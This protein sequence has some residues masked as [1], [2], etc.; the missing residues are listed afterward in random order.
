M[1][2]DSFGAALLWCVLLP[3][4]TAEE[5][6]PSAVEFDTKLSFA[7]REVTPEDFASAN[8]D[9]KIVEAP[10]RI[11]ANL[12][13]DEKDLDSIVYKLH[14]PPSVE[15]VD[16]LPKTELASDIAGPIETQQKTSARTGMVVSFEGGGKVGYRMPAVVDAAASAS[17]K[18]TDERANEVN[19]GVQMRLLP[20]KQLIVAAGTQNRGQTLYFKLRP[21]SQITLEGERE[22]ACLLVVPKDWS[23]ECITLDCSAYAK[24][25]R[26]AV[27]RQTIGIGLYAS[28]DDV[29]R[30]RVETLAK[31]IASP[32]YLAP[33]GQE[34][35]TLPAVPT[36]AVLSCSTCAGTYKIPFKNQNIL[37]ETHI[38]IT[39]LKKDGTWEGTCERGPH[40]Y[41]KRGTWS[42]EQGRLTIKGSERKVSSFIGSLGWKK[43]EVVLYDDANIKEFDEKHKTIY[44]QTGEI[45]RPER[46]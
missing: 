5:P 19:S 11:S 6:K 9:R 39:E 2:V 26:E 22:F 14:M 45:L 3:W 37:G 25:A 46:E 27:A 44:L 33:V 36:T 20:P 18:R 29:A 40:T 13:I 23:G 12:A 21:F 28:G 38:Y 34:P 32:T 8:K 15:I 17:G 43:D 1:R 16:Y 24:S 30:V 35:A 4:A 31:V 10:L 41:A 7:C 42:I